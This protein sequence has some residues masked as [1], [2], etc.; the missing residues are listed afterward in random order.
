MVGVAGRSKACHT[1]RQ[2]RIRCGAERP[3]CG[4]CLKS[5]RSCA[6]Y[7]RTHVFIS[8]NFTQFGGV[9]TLTSDAPSSLSRRKQQQHINRQ[10]TTA[11]MPRAVSARNAT[12]DQFLAKFIDCQLPSCILTSGHLNDHRK[13]L[14]RLP[15]IA[16]L[17]PAMEYTILALS[18]AALEQDGDLDH[19]KG[20]G[21]KLYTRG[22]YELQRAIDDPKMRLHDQT[23]AACVLLGMF[24]FSQC[25]GRTVSAYMRHYQGAMALLQI[26][27][28]E[29]HIGGLAHDVF[30]VLRMHTAFQGLS[31]KSGSQLAKPTWMEGPWV[32]KSKT[33]HDILLDIFL[34]VPKLLS[35]A[36]AVM[37]SMH[38]EL[39]LTAGLETL[40][41][42]LALNNELSKW[43]ESYQYLYPTLYWPQLSTSNSS[44]DS[45]ELGRLYPVSFQFLSYHVAETMVLHWTVQI[46]LHASI[47]SLCTR[48]TSSETKE[49]T[50][51]EVDDV[52]LKGG[53]HMSLA[54]I[55]HTIETSGFVSWPE[56]SARYI[57]QSVEYFF[58]EEFRSMG[59][60]A[61][62]SPLLVVKACLIRSAQNFSRE[63]AWIDEAIRRI[64]GNGAELAAC[65]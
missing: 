28:P 59:A 64:Q 14:L 3:S 11:A 8:S 5:G 30:Q 19:G 6:G 37:S 2:R 4:N 21:L 57:C 43:L 32:S 31:Q 9:Q 22:L 36:R 63:I 52:S 47:S 18:T 26:R 55:Q 39:S 50:C 53:D 49:L 15:D 46:L 54:D 48:L 38:S 1:C 42:L 56:T 35:Q 60:G 27:G 45:E 12:R 61:V 16:S 33:M 34:K 29:Q 58:Q 10:H 62:L 17:T 24:E 44:T 7:Q 23:L 40:T 41:G 51:F 20:Q 13:W 25:P 65:V